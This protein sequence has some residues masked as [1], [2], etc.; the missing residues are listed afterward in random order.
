MGLAWGLLDGGEFLGLFLADDVV[1]AFLV[2]L[3]GEFLAAAADD[4]AVDEDVDAIRD[5]V[6]EEALVV[7]DEGRQDSGR[8]GR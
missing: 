4:A 2:E 1:V 7:G 5:D 6:V 8:A 3:V